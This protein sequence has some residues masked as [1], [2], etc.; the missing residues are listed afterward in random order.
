MRNRRGAVALEFAIVA[1]PFLFMLFAIIESGMVFVAN[2]DL[3]NATMALAR[4]IRTGAVVAAGASASTKGVVLSLT[5]FKTAICSKM[6]LVS[7][8]TCINQLQVDLRSPSSFGG[9][10]NASSPLSN[11]NFNTA[12]LCYYSGSAGSVVEFRAFYLWPIATPMLFSALV[13]ASSYTVNGQTTTGNYRVLLSAE[14]FRVE[15]NA[16]GSNGGNGC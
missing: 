2:I 13:N 6:A 8:S 4:Q 3:S 10:Q 9:G 16:A 14:A 15:Q 7:N 1:A 12:S 5:D 11:G